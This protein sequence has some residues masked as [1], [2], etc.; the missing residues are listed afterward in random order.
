MTP[1]RRFD[2]ILYD[3]QGNV[4]D[5]FDQVTWLFAMSAGSFNRHVHIVELLHPDLE[6]PVRYD[7]SKG[8]EWE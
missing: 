4:V 5:A 8:Q 7:V 6:S 3:G 1:A 2:A